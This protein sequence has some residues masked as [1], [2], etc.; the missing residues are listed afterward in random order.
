[1]NDFT[2]DELLTLINWGM[3]LADE[4]P[5]TLDSD[6]FNVYAK[7]QLLIDNYCEHR[8]AL[9]CSECGSYLCEKCERMV[10]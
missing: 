8:K 7:I 10:E 2:K 1:M 5:D 4:F 9:Q 6:D 3:S